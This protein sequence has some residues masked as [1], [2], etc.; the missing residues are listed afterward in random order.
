M[1]KQ[2]LA[3]CFIVALLSTTALALP[4]SAGPRSIEQPQAK[5]YSIDE[6]R[7]T[8]GELLKAISDLDAEVAIQQATLAAANQSIEA[9]EQ[10]VN[11]NN[12]AIS[13]TKARMQSIKALAAE[14]AI[15]EYMRPSD[16]LIGQF[17]GAQDIGD[18]SRRTEFLSQLGESDSAISRELREITNE[19][20]KELEAAKQSSEVA[21]ER[22]KEVEKKLTQLNAAREQKAK[23]EKSLK[24][25]IAAYAAEDEASARVHSATPALERASRSGDS[26]TDD[27]GRVSGSGLRWP[28]ARHQV[29]SQFGYRWGR[30]HQGIDL[31][32]GIGTAIYAA[33]AGKVESAGWESGYGQYTCI[34]HGS[35]FTSCYA[36]Q[37][38]I[39]VSAGESV[40]TGQLI[41][42]TGN[43]GASQGAHLHFE[44]RVNGVAKNPLQYLP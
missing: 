1:K 31:E 4:A 39:N 9:A 26:D 37:S 27:D 42:Y 17:L 6:L 15:E 23:L 24:E 22:K 36:H 18:A 3:T 16:D 44:T 43:T 34:D 40:S 14:R 41:G 7:A 21:A 28:L 8:D 35:G 11:A 25:R 5:T 19:L 10:A 12:Q 38:R 32:A 30:M 20:N 13:E 29:N 33:K 2:V